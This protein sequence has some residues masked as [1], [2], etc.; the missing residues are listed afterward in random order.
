MKRNTDDYIT[1]RQYPILHKYYRSVAFN[2]TNGKL[3]G[4]DYAKVIETLLSFTIDRYKHIGTRIDDKLYNEISQL[5]TEQ[6]TTIYKVIESALTIGVKYMQ[7]K[8]FG[9]ASAIRILIN[10]YNNENPDNIIK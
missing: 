3:T 10:A 9:V 1:E 6:N 8:G 7:K 2:W 5:A 4:N